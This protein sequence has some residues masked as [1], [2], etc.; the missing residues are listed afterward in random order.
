MK[1][2]WILSGAAVAT[3]AILLLWQAQPSK[4]VLM[5]ND[6]PPIIDLE[7]ASPPSSEPLGGIK[8]PANLEPM[9]AA[10]YDIDS[11]DQITPD[12]ERGVCFLLIL[13]SI[14]TISRLMTSNKI[15]GKR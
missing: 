15:A 4:R 3:A 9:T 1:T 11:Q 6:H 10:R 2:V 12:L 14:K 5:T 7:I 8:S 13:R